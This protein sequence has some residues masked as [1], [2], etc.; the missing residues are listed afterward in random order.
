[1]ICHSGIGFVDRIDGISPPRVDY[2]AITCATC[3]DPHSVDNPHQ[4]R[5]TADVILNDVSAPG[6]ATVITDGGQ[7]KLCM[8][9]HKSRRDAEVYAQSYHRHYG[10]HYG[11]QADML[12][13]ANAV[14]YGMD[15][16]SSGH[17]VAVEDACVTCHLQETSRSD[18]AHGEAGGHTFKMKWDAGTED[19]A[20]DVD[21]VG[22]C[23]N[24]HGDITTFDFPRQDYDGDGVL[25]G[26]QTEVE[27][28][29]HQLAILLPPLDDPAV[30]VTSDYTT[31]QLQGAYNYIMVEDDGSKGVHNTSFAV[32]LLKAS[33]ATLDPD[34]DKD[35]LLDE[36][37]W[38][39]LGT[40]A[41]IGT[42]DV[43]GDGLNNMMEIGAATHPMMIDTD[44]DGFDDLSELRAGS[45][46]TD[47]NDTPGFFVQMLPA[48]ELEFP[49]E[50]GKT[51]AIQMI[52]EL[53]AVWTN[54]A[55][56]MPG[57]GGPMTHLIST[58]DGGGQAFYRAVEETP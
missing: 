6:G 27:G 34:T 18:P 10:P 19:P 56:N 58:R 57:T 33:I 48:A 45:D 15:I 44:G 28:L 55:T 20:D 23:V 4:V 39:T 36:W 9:C 38:E 51:Y 25:E 17:L 46:P 41:Y 12:A 1:V 24:C 7:G 30:S 5:T 13:G 35:G 14:F 29:M 50:M 49:S 32:G 8:N 43:D 11:P 37:E 52:S 31:L 26:V 53:N 22:A 42:D 40:L 16:P 21:L 47:M 3:H 2:E 54:V